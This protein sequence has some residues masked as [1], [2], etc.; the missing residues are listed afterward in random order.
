MFVEVYNIWLTKGD[1]NF[2][3]CWEN[4]LGLTYVASGL[5]DFMGTTYQN[6]ENIP[7]T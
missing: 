5:P 1:K 4:I 3:L 7:N 6:G 2:K